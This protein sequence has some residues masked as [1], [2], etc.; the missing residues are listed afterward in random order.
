MPISGFS[1][2]MAPTFR[3]N[4]DCEYCYEHRT[5][6]VMELEDLE[7]ILDRLVTYFRKQEVKEL[8]LFWQGGEIF[9]MTPEWLLRAH[10]TVREM[11]ERRAGIKIQNALQSNLVGFSPRW[12][13]VVSEMFNNYVGSSLDFPNLYRKVVGGTPE[14]FNDIWFR[15]Y[16]Q[17]REAGIHVGAIAVLNDASLNIGAEEFYAYYVEKLGLRHFQLNT[18]H[19]GGPNTPAKQ[20]FPLNNKP[21]SVFYSEL[22]DLWMRQGRS[23]GVSI[24]PFDEAVRYFQTGE[25]RLA[26]SWAE[27]CANIFLA[28]G[29]KGDVGQCECWVSSYP[30]HMFGNILSCRDITDIMSS[31]MRKQFLDRPLRLMEDEDCAECEFLNICHGG[32]PIHAYSATGNLF[33]KDPNCKSMKTLFSLARNAAIELDRLESTRQAELPVEASGLA[34][35]STERLVINH[36]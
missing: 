24:S 29:P 6:D 11:G 21:L 4:A 2:L 5:S 30:N 14:A 19:R 31:P 22:F 33:V 10:D 36:E 3:C 18:P 1:V 26:C 12:G 15:R 25:N 28:V 17:A 13:R 34:L 35:S 32:C 20:K 7:R 9:T 16:Q 27:N 23:D 8:Q